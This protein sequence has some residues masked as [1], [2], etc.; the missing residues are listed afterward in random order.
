MRLIIWILQRLSV[1]KFLQKVKSRQ[2]IKHCL[3]AKKRSASVELIEE[4]MNYGI[5]RVDTASEV[6][7]DALRICELLGIDKELLIY[8]KKYIDK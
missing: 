1:K 2:I 8:V 5:I 4:Y 3:I 6:P 7:K